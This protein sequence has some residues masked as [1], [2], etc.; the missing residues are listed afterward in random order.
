[1]ERVT[2]GIQSTEFDP[3][4]I[5]ERKR[6]KTSVV[7]TCCNKSCRCDCWGGDEVVLKLV[8]FLRDVPCGEGFFLRNLVLKK[9]K[10]PPL[11]PAVELNIK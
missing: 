6:K 7:T 2:D 11:S 10:R 9:T 4:P 1:M 3:H 5:F 8:Q